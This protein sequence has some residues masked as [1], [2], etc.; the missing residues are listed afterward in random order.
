MVNCRIGLLFRTLHQLYGEIEMA[1]KEA[2]PKG[3]QAKILR[4]RQTIDN[5]Q[6]EYNTARVERDETEKNLTL[7][8]TAIGELRTTNNDLFQRVDEANAANTA[9]VSEIH[10]LRSQIAELA[11]HRDRLI[12]DLAAAEKRAETMEED[13]DLRKAVATELH[14][15]IM[16]L[17]RD[18]R[19]AL[20]GTVRQAQK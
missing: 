15:L 1:K 6:A 3:D 14:D 20:V 10:R 17:H 4:L 9:M 8:N 5:L 16:D 12:Q 11:E 7:A 2:T 18:L 19:G 13:A